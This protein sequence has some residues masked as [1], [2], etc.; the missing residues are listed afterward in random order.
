VEEYRK[1]DFKELASPGDHGMNNG[2]RAHII[3]ASECEWGEWSE[4]SKCSKSCAV[5]RQ[6][7][8]QKL[9][10][11][12][13]PAWEHRPDD[14]ECEGAKMH[15]RHC[16]QHH[17][18]E[19]GGGV[20]PNW[21]PYPVPGENKA[22]R[23]SAYSG[24]KME[25]SYEGVENSTPGWSAEIES[26]TPGWSEDASEPT[27]DQTTT[28]MDPSWTTTISTTSMPSWDS[29]IPTTMGPSWDSPTTEGPSDMPPL[30]RCESKRDCKGQERLDVHPSRPM[31]HCDMGSKKASSYDNKKGICS[32]RNKCDTD[33]D[34]I[35]FGGEAVMVCKKMRS[36]KSGKKG[37]VC[38]WTGEIDK[39]PEPTAYEPEPERYV[40]E[41]SA[42]TG[43]PQNTLV[44]CKHKRDCS[45]AQRCLSGNGYGKYDDDCVAMKHCDKGP[46]KLYKEEGVCTDKQECRTD[47]D[48]AE[49]GNPTDGI[50]EMKCKKMRSKQYGKISR[51]C[52]WTGEVEVE[53]EELPPTLPLIKCQNRGDCKYGCQP[54]DDDNCE[55]LV[56]CDKGVCN[57]RQECKTDDDCG[58]IGDIDTGAA[59]RFCLGAKKSRWSRCMIRDGRIKYA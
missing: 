48:C 37:K 47:S 43:E 12:P 15:H 23:Y 31:K 56:Y 32:D 35:K 46:K 44:L 21:T 45:N 3:K 14:F 17:C 58:D 26:S 16:N 10:P 28:A 1:M 33:E 55:G 5:G 18:D 9:M 36:R 57:D 54:D 59:E 51:H 19:E 8:K 34:C 4:W 30:V 39:Q 20:E 27:W 40:E 6:E 29:T 24:R 49:I 11:P 13:K 50:A 42:E 53:E 52:R 41:Q 38:R 22:P 7:R 25:T 2:I